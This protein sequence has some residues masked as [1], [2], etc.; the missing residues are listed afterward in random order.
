MLGC[1][2]AALQI[3]VSRTPVDARNGLFL[4]HAPPNVDLNKEGDRAEQ[5]CCL[6]QVPGEQEEYSNRCA[7][8]AHDLQQEFHWSEWVCQK[9]LNPFC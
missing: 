6:A 9:V 3:G 2:S 8:D 7:C 4:V 1:I 5:R